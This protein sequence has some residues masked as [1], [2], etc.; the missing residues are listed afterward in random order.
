MQTLFPSR[1]RW[2]ETRG[3]EGGGE[4]YWRKVSLEEQDSFLPPPPLDPPMWQVEPTSALFSQAAGGNDCEAERCLMKVETPVIIIVFIIPVAAAIPSRSGLVSPRVSLKQLKDPRRTWKEAPSFCS[5]ELSGFFS[6]TSGSSARCDVAAWSARERLRPPTK[7]LLWE[8][9]SPLVYGYSVY[10]RLVVF[11]WGSPVW[12]LGLGS[13]VV[14]LVGL[15]KQF[16]PQLNNHNGLGM[17]LQGFFS[18]PWCWSR[19]HHRAGHT[20]TDWCYVYQRGHSHMMA[21][22]QRTFLLNNGEQ[23]S[24]AVFTVGSIHARF[25]H[26]QNSFDGLHSLSCKRYVSDPCYALITSCF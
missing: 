3:W 6:A 16:S 18:V 21:Y 2:R 13:T 8:M 24:R 26:K 14:C 7:W 5:S 20:H 19:L 25:S 11:V 12:L 9:M 1:P 4:G 22:F 10:L 15:N 17:C 23:N